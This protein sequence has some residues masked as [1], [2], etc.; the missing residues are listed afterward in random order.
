MTRR[1]QPLGIV[2]LAIAIGLAPSGLES[3]SAAISIE[4]FVKAKKKWPSQV[5]LR[6][7]I[8]GRYAVTA[9]LDLA[10]NPTIKR[11]VDWQCRNGIAIDCLLVFL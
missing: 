4:E 3:V 9:M 7:V 11:K 10:L 2:V 1:H 8:E 5:G 6:Q